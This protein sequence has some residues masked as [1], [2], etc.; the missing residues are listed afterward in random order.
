MIK[1]IVIILFFSLG[2]FVGFF[3]YFPETLTG[4]DFSTY[5]LYC[6]IFLVGVD[7]GADKKTFKALKRMNFKVFTAPISVILGTLGGVAIVSPL[8]QGVSFKESLAV[9]AGFGYYSLSSVFITKIS[10]ETL[11]IIALISNLTREIITLLFT[12]ILIK[13]FGKLAPIA[14]G[15]AT[16]MDTTLP[17]ITKFSGSEYAFISILNGFLLTALVPFFVTLILNL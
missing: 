12:P 3:D 5:T 2:V 15:G 16:S 7:I 10:G 4:F 13:F 11:G 17:V 1:S 8:I 6:L 14:S 9:G